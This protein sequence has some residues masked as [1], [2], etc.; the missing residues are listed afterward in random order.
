MGAATTIH[1]ISIQTLLQ[2]SAA[3][4]MVGRMLSLW[5]MITRA[6]PAMGALIY[7]AAAEVF[8]L[9][10]PVL[11]GV[12]LCMAMWARTWLRLGRL[13]PA[14]AIAVFSISSAA[15][16]ATT[17]S[18]KMPR[19]TSDRP[20]TPLAAQSTICA[21]TTRAISRSRNDSSRFPSGPRR[22]AGS[23]RRGRA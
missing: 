23:P 1:G 18:A 15:Y 17:A 19:C 21:V 8:G 2:N 3:P 14:L 16:P 9:R 12:A 10:I 22:T 7:G 20:P 5:G 4:A 6:A 11:I 13:A